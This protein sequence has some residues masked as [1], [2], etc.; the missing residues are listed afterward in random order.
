MDARLKSIGGLIVFL[1]AAGGVAC[2]AA[3][4]AYDPGPRTG[5][6]AGGPV[7]GLTP[8]ETKLFN[9]GRRRF[10][11]TDTVSGDGL[12]PRMNFSSCSGCHAQPATGGSSAKSNPQYQF[13]QS[14]DHG[15]NVLPPFIT[16]YGPTREAR[17]RKT[18]TG[19]PD[20][21]VHDLFTISG[22]KG[23]GACKLSQPD[24][25]SNKS[26][27]IYRIPTPVFGAGLIEQ[28]RDRD[29]MNNLGKEMPAKQRMQIRGRLNV[30]V[31]GNTRTQQT[32]LAG[33]VN[34]NGNDGTIARF[35]WKAQNKSLLIFAGEAYN[36]EMGISNELFQTEREED[37]PN[38]AV[39]MP[40]D[41]TNT[42]PGQI[43]TPDP[44]YDVLSDIETFAAFMRFLAPPKAS[45][46]V[47]G[48]SSSILKGKALFG[49]V[50]CSLCHT[51]VLTTDPNSRIAALAGKP[52][53]LYSD[54]ALHVMGDNLE[55]GISQGEA[56]GNEFRTAPLWGLGQRLFFLHDGRTSD[57]I[58]AI[59]EHRGKNSEANEVVKRYERLKEV[60]KQDLLNFLRSL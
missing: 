21:G 47:P 8:G 6:D 5:S 34:S 27:I 29:I 2:F 18:N 44:P 26:N 1:A 16:E 25:A 57:L 39:K 56:T 33:E 50:G 19:V 58:V 11:K 60:D 13:M 3:A 54:L 20:G 48:G 31:S 52:A 28:I 15:N 32:R 10:L 42:N 23:A 53:N 35:G 9:T 45:D 4:K 22:M 24:F 59:Q 30:V 38:T 55:D 17:F 12:G 43:S 41:G 36:V 7:A 40:N 37:C 49:D 14:P 46:S 51:P